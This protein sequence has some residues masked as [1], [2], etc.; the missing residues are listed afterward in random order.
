MKLKYWIGIFFCPLLATAQ[1]SGKVVAVTDGDT[2]KVLHNNM[3]TRIR[4]HG[5][6]CPE[7]DQDFSNVA[8]DFLADL[9]F[10][11]VVT[12]DSKKTDRYGRTIGIFW[13]QDSIN[14]NE[15]LLKAGLAWHYKYYDKN[16]DWA[17]LEL[18]AR[19]AKLHIWSRP[20]PIA[21]WDLRR[22]KT[23]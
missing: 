14:V 7:K 5:I 12:I 6:D 23:K 16:P 1:L 15:A 3:E 8:K 13:T 21:P 20:D 4:L 19:E 18:Q 2:F 10:S 22:I 17:K 9:I 11:K